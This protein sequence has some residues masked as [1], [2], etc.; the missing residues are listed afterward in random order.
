MAKAK[1][2]PAPTVSTI[3]G[4][5][6]ASSGGATADTSK[7][8]A[9]DPSLATWLVPGST[10]ALPGSGAGI[11]TLEGL[12]AVLG[13]S[14][15]KIK[16][17]EL[18]HA[19]IRALA[20]RL[21]LGS[22][23]P[24]EPGGTPGNEQPAA[25]QGE[26]MAGRAGGKAPTSGPTTRPYGGDLPNDQLVSEIQA[27][28]G[29]PLT[30]EEKGNPTAFLHD[31]KALGA[32]ESKLGIN[33]STS[34]ATTPGRTAGEEYSNFVKALDG[35]A[36]QEWTPG[37][38]KET[39]KAYM[40]SWLE[41]GNFLN[42]SANGGT[43]DNASIAGAY[44]NLL[45]QAKDTNTTVQKAYD[46]NNAS[47]NT[48]G[49][50]PPT[51]TVSETAAFVQGMGEKLGIYLSPA[52]VTKISNMYEGDVTNA[53]GPTSV[54]DEIKNTVVQYFNP[55]DPRNPP[56]A[57]STM[58]QDILQSAN[59][60]GIPV[61]SADIMN[62]VTNGIKTTAGDS[63]SIAQAASGTAAAAATHY[64]TLAEGL[65]P[66]LAPQIQSGQ[67]VSDLISPYNSI[68]AQ[69]TGVASSTLNDPGAAPGGPTGKY[70]SFLQGGRDPQT[71]APTMQTMDE[72]RK[73]LMQ[74]PKYGFQNTQ[75][76]RDMASQMSSAILNLF[77]KVNTMG[78]TSTPIQSALPGSGFQGDLSANT[79]GS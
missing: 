49:G 33:A 74:D 7:A 11:S 70:Y 65:Y 18:E 41:Q 53:G 72:W 19:V 10:G 57:A 62:W 69:Y 17:P 60:Y 50:Q 71:N 73:T 36:V 39:F 42:A 21:Q 43:P 13:V 45:K 67:K 68:T 76:A 28:T 12:A 23:Q 25:G 58:Y 78:G 20:E 15:V 63:Y 32:L 9:L 66:T 8:P 51:Q 48:P 22:T 34:P 56:G 44:Q 5:P 30:G 26:A 75:A 6:Y 77:G 35:T 54:E 4:T 64:Q 79:S 31:P 40:S 37:G 38:P 47:A 29:V 61:A 3:N 24:K 52:D 59:D 27:L 2:A 55:N 14:G 46:A 16:G 1:P